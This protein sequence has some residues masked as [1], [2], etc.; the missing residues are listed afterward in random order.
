[1]S[2]DHSQLGRVPSESPLGNH[3]AEKNFDQLLTID[4]VTTDPFSLEVETT[5]AIVV[6]TTPPVPNGT[7]LNTPSTRQLARRRR[8]R[9]RHG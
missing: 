7:L 2:H 3:H 6:N 8:Q 9:Q 4:I 1:M 5:T